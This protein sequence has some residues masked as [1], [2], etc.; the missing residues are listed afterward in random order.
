MK[1][2]QKKFNS[3]NILA[4]VA[5]LLVVASNY[6]LFSLIFSRVSTGRAFSVAIFAVFLILSIYLAW[7]IYTYTHDRSR[8][9][10]TMQ[11]DRQLRGKL[12]ELQKRKI[13][14][15]S[16]LSTE[17]RTPLQVIRGYASMLVDSSLGTLNGSTRKIAENILS[18]SNKA[19]TSADLI[20][21]MPL[22]VL[23]GDELAGI[24]NGNTSQYLSYSKFIIFKRVIF[25]ILGVSSFLGTLIQIL[26][27]QSFAG[28]LFAIGVS[29]VC[30]AIIFFVINELNYELKSLESTSQLSNDLVMVSRELE[31]LQR[32]GSLSFTQIETDIRGP[33]DAIRN[34]A[35]EL[36]LDTT[37]GISTEAK[38]VAKKIFELSESLALR[39]ADLVGTHNSVVNK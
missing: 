12:V 34:D 26:L 15:E 19:N 9:T 6:F 17:I 37:D 35:Q 24:R 10:I 11:K 33:L 18:Q 3:Y 2:F 7:D 14:L 16:D 21:S 5:G 27:A 1:Y 13:E 25:Y 4:L 28:L 31:A 39:V 30:V 29:L 8:L 32:E 38:E 36:S 23:S 20:I 22:A